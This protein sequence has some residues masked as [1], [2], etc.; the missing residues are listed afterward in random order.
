MSCHTRLPMPRRESDEDNAVPPPPGFTT[1]KNLKARRNDGA[2]HADSDAEG[3]EDESDANVEKQ[4]DES[5]G[6]ERNYTGYQ[7]YQFIKQWVTGEDAV[8][9]S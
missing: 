5:T 8:L 9:D 2:C 4:F 6:N 1:P 3:T 7:K